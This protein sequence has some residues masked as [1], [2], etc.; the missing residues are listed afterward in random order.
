M[1]CFKKL[2]TQSRLRFTPR[3]RAKDVAY[4]DF[5][6]NGAALRTGYMEYMWKT[7]AKTKRD[8]AMYIAYFE[9]WQWV[10]CASSYKEEFT[11]LINIDDF[12]NQVSFRFEKQAI[13]LS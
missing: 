9:P 11:G 12:R 13:P 2:P 8:K 10:I 3:S 5:V 1:G 4:V 6:Q 7:L